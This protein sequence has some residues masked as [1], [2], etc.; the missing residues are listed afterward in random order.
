MS[1]Q[2][3][4]PIMKMTLVLKTDLWWV[5]Q[6]ACSKWV[7]LEHQKSCF[8]LKLGP[9][10]DTLQVGAC[11]F[12]PFQ[13]SKLLSSMMT[14]HSLISKYY[15][16][17]KSTN[18]YMLNTRSIPPVPTFGSIWVV[19]WLLFFRSASSTFPQKTGHLLTTILSLK[20]SVTTTTCLL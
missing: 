15:Q 3:L 16:W 17:S 2:V 19:L 4:R 13:I 11:L 6:T 14:L 7:Q 18:H 5:L 8:K 20:L 1:W 10:S 12:P 9:L